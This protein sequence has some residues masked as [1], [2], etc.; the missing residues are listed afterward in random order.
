MDINSFLFYLTSNPFALAII[1]ILIFLSILSWYIILRKIIQLFLIVIFNKRIQNMFWHTQSIKDLIPL[2]Q[3]NAHPFAKILFK[4]IKAI[5]HYKTTEK[6][7]NSVSKSE[8]IQQILQ[9]GIT[10]E[11][12]KLFN[13]LT[14]LATI[15]STA[16]FI[17][18]LGTVMSIYYALASIHNYGQ[19]GLEN[20]ALPIGEALIMTAM[21]LLVAIPAV[22]SYNLLLRSQKTLI[23]SI[24][25]FSHAI[26]IYFTTGKKFN[27]S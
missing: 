12:E 8:F 25:H 7:N 13:G 20:I 19:A 2:L 23:Y 17:G 14:L 22:L 26:Y 3:K 4:T 9:T 6:Q 21:G 11:K 27:I 1:S 10:Q 18:L 5:L 16:P 24:N 15:G